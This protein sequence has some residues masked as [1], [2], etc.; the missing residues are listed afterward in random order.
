[1]RIA[2]DAAGRPDD[3]PDLNSAMPGRC[4]EG[5]RVVQDALPRAG[6]LDGKCHTSTSALRMREALAFDDWLAVGQSL[7]R[8]SRASAWWLG[9]WLVYGERAYGRRYKAALNVTALDY[10]TLRNYAWVARS[11]EMSRRRDSLS[12]QHH[13]ELAGR[14]EAEQELWL[15]RAETLRWTR[16]QL[17]REL[18]GPRR[19][20]SRASEADPVVL[21]LLVP[22]RRQQRWLEAAFAANQELVD[23]IAVAVDQAADSLLESE[24]R[25]ERRAQL[26]QLSEATAP[27]LEGRRGS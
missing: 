13:A 7:T 9:D 22:K 4:D 6:R 5:V 25:D 11:F 3:R 19:P 15:H 16:S 21:R 12:F 17:R 23:W 10:Q 8:F 18:A 26:A 14:N 2:P 1:M 20:R 24:P 27:P